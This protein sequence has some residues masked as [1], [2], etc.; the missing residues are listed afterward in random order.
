MEKTTDSSSPSQIYQQRTPIGVEGGPGEGIL[1]AFLKLSLHGVW[2]RET[3]SVETRALTKLKRLRD[4][5]IWYAVDTS[6]ETTSY[7]VMSCLPTC[8]ER[9]GGERGSI[10]PRGSM[11]VVTRR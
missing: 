6:M 10:P 2:S 3:E 1:V 4:K 9:Q 8:E 7:V 5:Y 11:G